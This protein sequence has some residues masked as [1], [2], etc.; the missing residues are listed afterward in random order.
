[1]PLNVLPEKLQFVAAAI[2]R[3]RIDGTRLPVLRRAACQKP[4]RKHCASDRRLFEKHCKF[5]N[6]LD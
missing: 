3:E 6:D 5:L 1:M 4:E 2:S